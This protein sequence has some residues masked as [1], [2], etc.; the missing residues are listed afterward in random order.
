LIIKSLSD[1]TLL[2]LLLLAACCNSR[3]II[4]LLHNN[5]NDILFSKLLCGAGQEGWFVGERPRLQTINK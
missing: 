5:D 3:Q 1:E 2:L 4:F